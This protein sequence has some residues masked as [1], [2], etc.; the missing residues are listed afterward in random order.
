MESVK[1][2]KARAG[3]FKDLC[4]RKKNIMPQKKKWSAQLTRVTAEMI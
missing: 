3:A 4:M 1:T 2:S